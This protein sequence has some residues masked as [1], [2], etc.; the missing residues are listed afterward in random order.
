MCS[1]YQFVLCASRM[2]H[3]LVKFIL[4]WE[5]WQA[6]AEMPYVFRILLTN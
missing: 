6:Y 4:V 1:A 2:L 3:F 5:Q